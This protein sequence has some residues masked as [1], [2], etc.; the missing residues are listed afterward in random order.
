[1]LAKPPGER[2]RVCSKIPFS[3]NGYTCLGPETKKSHTGWDSTAVCGELALGQVELRHDLPDQGRK[4]AL[5]NLLDGRS[6]AIC[7]FGRG[8]RFWS[9]KG[10]GG[11]IGFR[12]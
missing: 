12:G 10:D 6:E 4:L 5:H 1:M 2:R 7:V 3:R 11:G 8:Q 9:C